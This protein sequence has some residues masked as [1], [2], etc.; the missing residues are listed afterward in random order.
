M[1]KQV[2]YLADN[3]VDAQQVQQ[4][5]THIGLDVALNIV[6]TAQACGEAL[7]RN[8]YDLMI[9]EAP[10]QQGNA[11]DTMSLAHRYQP[12]LPFILLVD[13][14]SDFPALA[15]LCH[16][17]AKHDLWTLKCTAKILLDPPPAESSL[18]QLHLHNR[19]Q[20]DLL[21]LSEQVSQAR[22]QDEI[23]SLILSAVRNLALAD[24][25]TFILR[26]GEQSYYAEEDAIAPLWLGQ[27]HVLATCLGGQSMLQ[28]RQIAIPDIYADLKIA[29]AYYRPTFVRSVVMTP[30]SQTTAP[31]A[32]IGA[33]WAQPHTPD[34]AALALLQHLAAIAAQALANAQRY[35]SL[36]RTVEERT[37][38][39]ENMNHD[40]ESFAYSVAHDL[41]KPL[42]TINGFG[43]ILLQDYL[44]RM[45][46]DA[47]LYLM[48]ICGEAARINEQ[49]EDLLILFQLSSFC[50]QRSRINLHDMTQSIMTQLRRRGPARQVEVKIADIMPAYADA[51]LVNTLLE[52]LLSN[53]WK[54]SSH[55]S[56]AQIEIG[57]QPDAR[58]GE[59]FYISDN[60]AGFDMDP[61]VRLFRP[62][63]RYH[64][65]DEFPGSGMGLAIAQRIVHQHGGRIW[66]E[67]TPGVGATFFFTLP[68][69]T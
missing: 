44:L 48:R 11:E 29:H 52:K 10:P 64:A 39:L 18:Q 31:Q 51:A 57:V 50:V 59:V 6:T 19:L 65:A 56:L 16:I 22:R 41:R 32:A 45:P 21:L 2:L 33:Y 66:A 55:R 1:V 58:G 7:Q 9:S 12:R 24:G 36:E 28:A 23:L 43:N 27:R 63:Q 4:A 54:F 69:T 42:T 3:H 46:E 47:R 30:V 68:H 62:F 13:Q 49:L 61:P 60:G 34:A 20:T 5:L 26:E 25:A 67:S 15:G 53:A 37:A 17:V 35:R 38:Q 40:L 14:P 8:I